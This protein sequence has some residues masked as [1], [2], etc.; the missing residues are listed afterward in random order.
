VTTTSVRTS[1]S[2]SG[3]AGDGWTERLARFGLLGK[4]VVHVVIGL[5]ALQIAR[6]G[7]SSSEASTA[8][9]LDYIRELPLGGA[10][11]WV[12]GFSLLAL[13]VW[14]A[15]TTVDGDPV[16]D[17][18]GWYRAVWAAKALVYGALAVAFLRG[19][20]DG[21]SA[22]AGASDEDRAAQ[23]T[24]T[25][26]DWPMGRWLVVLAGL[27][28]IGIAVHLVVKHAVHQ[29]FVG[30][31]RVGPGST[32]ATLGRVGY[33]LRSLAYVLVGALLVQAGLAGEEQRAK[34]LSG[35][36]QS[37]A[38]ATG[39]RLLLFGVALGFVAYGAYC[40]AEARFRRSA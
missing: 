6:T 25:V 29:E 4:G 23:A 39:G 11:L 24:S 20:M 34:G 15:I 32:A 1:A 17:D 16:E 19:A 2:P 37:A 18:D 7:S 26:F 22:S 35:A 21:G 14:R 33:G 12:M 28:V 40:F 31:L 13:A 5:L 30:R 27:A 8:G 3:G 38:D 9:T 36:L 10:A